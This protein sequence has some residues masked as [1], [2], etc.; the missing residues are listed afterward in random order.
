MRRSALEPVLL[1][2]YERETLERSAR[3]PKSAQALALR[4]RVVLP[5]AEGG[6]NIEVAERLGLHPDTV[7]AP[8][9]P[10]R[11]ARSV[12]RRASTRDATHDR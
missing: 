2:D 3:R 10:R 6:H 5:C 9:V 8:P 1:S 12:A 4:C 7:V 11:S